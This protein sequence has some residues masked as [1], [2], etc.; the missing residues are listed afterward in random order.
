MSAP[1]SVGEAEDG[2]VAIG[3]VRWRGR[4]PRRGDL[5]GS[6]RSVIG[7]RLSASNGGRRSP[8]LTGP[9]VRFEWCA[10]DTRRVSPRALRHTQ[11]LK[12][13]VDGALAK[14]G[15]QIIAK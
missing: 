9:H 3:P 8:Y 11:M 10:P 1:C 2:E 15:Y 4:C 6:E 13:L 5:I 7:W 14:L 12:N